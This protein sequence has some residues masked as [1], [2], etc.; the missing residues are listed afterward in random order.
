MKQGRLLAAFF[1]F[2]PG[3]RGGR[4]VPLICRLI[5]PARAFTIATLCPP[6]RAGWLEANMS[7]ELLTV[8]QMYAADHAAM[9][10]GISGPTLMEAA[11]RAVARA[12]MDLSPDRPVPVLVLCGPG[13]NGGDGFVAARH[14]EEAGWPVRVGLL[15][16]RDGLRGDA[17]WAAGRWDGPALP[18]EPGLL[19]GAAIIVDALFGAGLSRPLDGMALAM[20]RAIAASGRPVVAV[21]VPSGVNGDDGTIQGDAAPATVTV[22]FFR[23]KPGHYLYPGRGLCGRLH[24]ADIGIPDSVLTGIASQIALNGPDLW[25]ADFPRPT[26]HSHKYTRGHALIFGGAVMTGAAR[27]AAR[28]ALRLGAGLVTLACPQAAQLVYSLSMPS[29][30]VHPLTGTAEFAKLLADPRRNAILLGPGAGAGDEL[31]ALA[32]AALAAGRSGVLDADIFSSFQGDLAGLKVA[33]LDGRW[34][35]TPHE[36]EFA[37]LFGNGPGSRLDRA[38]RAAA[39]SGAIL[40]LKG[41]DSLIAHPDGRVRIN[42]NA[43]ADLATAGSG[44]VLA[45]MILALLAQGMDPFDAA[46]AGVWFHGATGRECG[47]GLIAEDLPEA[48]PV[49]LRG[50]AF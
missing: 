16:A 29:L 36:G 13:N 14:L 17:A 25:R 15:G 27:L 45:G 7:A 20:V 32:G 37:R 34:V 41:A 35:L 2:G 50:M 3:R 23:P 43:P 24:I 33:G 39:E 21:D 22:S 42:H 48:L 47:P 1:I 6:A 9:V 12:V 18:A 8:A 30:I 28:A 49:V 46:S 4:T 19:Q 31:R 44:D 10:A 26:P 38:R 5:G 11:G 40:V